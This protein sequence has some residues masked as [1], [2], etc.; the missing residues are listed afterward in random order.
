LHRVPR[1]SAGSRLAARGSRL[2][3]RGSRLVAQVLAITLAFFCLADAAAAQREQPAE[4]KIREVTNFEKS[5]RVVV[6]PK[7]SQ[8]FRKGDQIPPEFLDRVRKARELAARKLA[9]PGG[10]TSL[11][12]IC[13]DEDDGEY[14]YDPPDPDGEDFVRVDFWDVYDSRGN[15]GE[16]ETI[17]IV[18]S[19]S[20]CTVL[21]SG[22]WG[23]GDALCD[24]LSPIAAGQVGEAKEI[25]SQI[26]A[27]L[28]P[29]IQLIF[30]VLP[31]CAVTPPTNAVKTPDQDR[32]QKFFLARR[33]VIETFASN[34]SFI[35]APN[36]V[37]VKYPSGDVIRFVITSVTY[38]DN[39]GD[40]DVEL[41]VF[42]NGQADP[43]N[44]PC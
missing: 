15:W 8:V 27:F 12:S 11:G 22:A 13:F 1:L 14:C 41:D 38:S 42:L 21:A 20:P 35:E 4:G 5:G 23:S 39:L 10:R 43:R 18:A 37:D 16:A 40:R 34:F 44:S 33:T 17:I 32:S 24:D 2:A 36:R 19:R 25:S 30:V 28:E 7:S 29:V 31:K 3:A 9:R 6:K 26:I